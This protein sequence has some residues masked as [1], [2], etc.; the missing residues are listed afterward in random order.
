VK[1]AVACTLGLVMLLV[2][3]AP[4]AEF[5]RWVDERGVVHFT[6]SLHAVPQKQRKNATRIKVQGPQ[7]P[8]GP[9]TRTTVPIQKKGE[10][11]IV[12][13]ILNE[14][15]T[16]LF[17]V[18]TGA[19]YT[20]LS[21]ATATALGIDLENRQTVALQTANGRIQAPLVSLETID[22]GGLQI[23][24]VTAAV[25]D[26]FPDGTISGLLGLNFLRHFRLDID[27]QNGLL[28]LERR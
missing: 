13:A 5:Y 15:S 21:P 1:H 28:T 18:D 4:A 24:N 25:H 22:V 17:I 20:M 19:S 6:D 9:P 10:V 26:V 27:T 11:V 23:K 12:P 14:K 8:P 2:A 7:E 16:A 3:A